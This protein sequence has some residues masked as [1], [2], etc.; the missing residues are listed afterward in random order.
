MVKASHAGLSNMT[1]TLHQLIFSNYFTDV[2]L[3]LIG[4]IYINR[5]KRKN[6]LINTCEISSDLMQMGRLCH[7]PPPPP[8]IPE[9]K[10]VIQR[11]N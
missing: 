9:R 3:K 7:P 4:N 2:Y 11:G 6:G 8:S 5:H 10:H 1:V